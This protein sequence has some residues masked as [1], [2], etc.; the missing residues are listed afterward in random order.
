MIV[1]FVPSHLNRP[2]EAILTS[3][4]HD[5]CF[6]KSKQNIAMFYLD[7]YSR[8]IQYSKGVLTKL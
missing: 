3:S 6:E 2:N 1:L 5:L 4:N 7:D 8:S